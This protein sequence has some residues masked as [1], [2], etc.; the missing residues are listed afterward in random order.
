MMVT[1][2]WSY[3]G[4]WQKTREDFMSWVCPKASRLLL[5]IISRIGREE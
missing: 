1:F 4:E 3:L 2:A 5:L